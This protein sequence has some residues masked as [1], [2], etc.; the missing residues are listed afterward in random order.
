MLYTVIYSVYTQLYISIVT[1]IYIYPQLTLWQRVSTVRRSSSVQKRTF[2][3][4]QQSEHSMG[5]HFVY[6]KS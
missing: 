1:F 5:S 4:V 3:K 6:S 2:F